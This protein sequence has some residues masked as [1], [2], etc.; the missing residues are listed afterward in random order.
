MCELN[1]KKKYESFK[2]IYFVSNK[3]SFTII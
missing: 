3:N 1:R 2:D